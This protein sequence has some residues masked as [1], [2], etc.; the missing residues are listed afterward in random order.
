M[1]G[2]D[3]AGR[4]NTHGSF[5]PGTSLTHRLSFGLPGG[6][7]PGEGGGL[8]DTGVPDGI[9]ALRGD[10][11]SYYGAGGSATLQRPRST[12]QQHALALPTSVARTPVRA[13]EGTALIRRLVFD[14]AEGSAVAVRH[15]QN[16]LQS[17]LV[18]GTSSGVLHGCDLRS[19]RE[20]WVGRLPPA[21]GSLTAL[22]VCPGSTSA[23]VGTDRGVI[24]L[25]DFRFDCVTAA[26]RHSA[27]SPIR[28]LYPY[29][30]VDVRPYAS[31]LD[32]AAA[33]GASSGRSCGAA[34]GGAVGGSDS[35]TFGSGAYSFGYTSG[36]RFGAS[37]AEAGAPSVPVARQL[38]VGVACG[39]D[40]VSFW[41]LETGH[42]YR[43]LRNLPQAVAAADA[44]RLP[45]LSRI[46]MAGGAVAPWQVGAF[47]GP[48]PGRGSKRAAAARDGVSA[49]AVDA[50][51]RV[52]AAS[53][54]HPLAAAARESLTLASPARGVRALLC[55]MPTSLVSS[56]TSSLWARSGALGG[57]GGL[58]APG[59]LGAAGAG[60][61]GS[62]MT[63]DASSSILLGGMGAGGS[64]GSV[65][66]A[67]GAGAIGSP[68]AAAA[69]VGFVLGGLRGAGA[70]RRRDAPFAVGYRLADGSSSDIVTA[71]L[72]DMYRGG[73]GVGGGGGGVATSSLHGAA[74]FS[75]QQR[76]LSAVGA[77]LAYQHGGSSLEGLPVWILTAGSDRSVRCWDLERPR[78]SH[79]V[80]GLAPGE[81]RDGYEA[82]WLWPA[83]PQPWQMDGSAGSGVGDASVSEFASCSGD[84]SA[85]ASRA[86]R[87]A[88][89]ESHGPE[90]VSD[91]D[92]D[93]GDGPS[94]DAAALLQEVQQEEE[95]ASAAA[96][97]GGGGT[98]FTHRDFGFDG[99][100]R[101]RGSIAT[102]SG[103]S[104]RAPGSAKTAA[105]APYVYGFQYPHPVRTVFAQP[106]SD[107]SRQMHAAGG[108]PTSA[109]GANPASQLK[110][111]IPASTAH[112]SIITAMAWLDLPTRLLLT[113]SSD[114]VVKV[115]R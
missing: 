107:P 19:R 40:E 33:A 13:P 54:G 88:V 104:S 31:P 26:W 1:I 109:A 16:A 94:A 101:A 65:G 36:A 61:G 30:T 91:D 11:S 67:G 51:G 4:R 47:C 77:P 95:A 43:L 52:L 105:A 82:A 96:A 23:V 79:T 50:V 98:H 115:W 55:P 106:L 83:A 114:G 93:E 49:S 39:E 86:R 73:V 28:A 76:G 72:G 44:Y 20:A 22:E 45:Y 103:R 6:D 41:N 57:S 84:A 17:V 15:Y 21:F 42:C 69:G 78:A 68:A 3:F 66:G 53:A 29:V 85:D 75:P 38:A 58:G 102:G 110:G 70:T 25:W 81:V 5:V 37:A 108:G 18:A 62:G 97:A 64:G 32:A 92:D 63:D 74:G 48:A 2:G 100:S 60:F 7:S 112:D 14:A 9:G 56:V 87:G 99:I 113:G 34:A 111:P 71:T 35:G 12:Q 59:S 46:E 80:C 27:R 89:A 8:V 24:A 90:Y 10:G